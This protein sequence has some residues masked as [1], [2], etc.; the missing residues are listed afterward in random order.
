MTNQKKR[1]VA[2]LFGGRGSEHLISCKSAASIA[3]ALTGE[4]ELYTVGITTMGDFYLFG[5]KLSD[6]ENGTWA[7]DTDHLFPVFFTRRAGVG[8]LQYEDTVLPVDVVLPALH[9]D[10]GED[11][12]IQGMLETCAIPF[13]GAKTRGGVMSASKIASKILAEHLSIPTVPWCT[14]ESGTPFAKAKLMLR[15]RFGADEYPLILKPDTLGSSIGIQTVSS[16]E[17]LRAALEQAAPYGDLLVERYLPGLREIELCYLERK[18]A[19]LFVIGEVCYPKSSG[20]TDIYS[21][22]KKYRSDV[23]PFRRA[24][25]TH[26]QEDTLCHY[27]RE[28]IA[29]MHLQGLSRIDFF[30]GS[31]GEIFFNEINAFPGFTERSFYPQAMKTVGFDYKTLLLTLLEQAY[32]L[33]I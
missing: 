23:S 15:A 14:M 4:C 19:P 13:V 21:Y 22:D 20:G 7:E 9:G 28:L 8:G 17:Q 3:R 12:R 31:E 30:L 2:L 33:S 18:E 25:L 32:D 29:L 24:P 26:R 6:M 1:R 5:G 11:G 10:F 27:A 16:D